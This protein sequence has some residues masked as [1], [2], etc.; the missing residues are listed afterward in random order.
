MTAFFRRD[1]YFKE[2]G[3]KR[4]GHI[5]TKI[6][7]LRAKV[8]LKNLNLGPHSPHETMASD[9]NGPTTFSRL[10]NLFII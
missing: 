3:G 4:G 1:T 2:K 6:Y 7:F 8:I 9:S 10:H 5:K